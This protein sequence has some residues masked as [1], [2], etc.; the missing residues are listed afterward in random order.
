MNGIKCLYRITKKL[1]IIPGCFVS[2]K[3]DALYIVNC[4][5]CFFPMT[6]HVRPFVCWPKLHFH[7]PI[8]ALVLMIILIYF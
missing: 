4:W 7:A 2:D 3:I 1:I 8:E 5:K 6:P